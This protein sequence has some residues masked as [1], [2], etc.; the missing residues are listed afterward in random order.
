VRALLA[1]GDRVRVLEN[2]LY[3]SAPLREVENHPNLETVEGDFRLEQVAIEA[4]QDVESV[5]HL[6][7]IVGDPACALDNDFTIETNLTATQTLAEAASRAGVQR[8]IFAS[9]CSVYGASDGELDENSALNPVSL[10]ATTKIAAENQLLG[11]DWYFDPVVLRFAT[12]YGVSP[13]PR[14]DLVIN[15]LTAKALREGCITIHGGNQWRPFVHVEDLARAMVMTLDA[16]SPVIAGQIFNVGATPENYRLSTVGDTIKELIPSA[17]VETS[18]Q[19][20]DCRNYYVNFDKIRDSLGFSPLH[21]IR[22]GIAELRD[23]LSLGKIGDH[24]NPL[25][26]NHHF[27]SRRELVSLAS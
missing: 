3:G 13:R 11:R 1:R 25:Y 17:E 22:S 21:T 18:D 20:T 27:L 23:H 7:A 26:S 10:Y 9:T 8:F 24:L 14:F 5:V 6:G 2:F 19:I 15:L 12:V 4:V 16:P